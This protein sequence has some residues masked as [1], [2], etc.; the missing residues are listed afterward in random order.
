MIGENK[1]ETI[2]IAQ[3]ESQYKVNIEIKIN[4]TD[5]LITTITQSRVLT[6]NIIP[7][8]SNDT[9]MIPV[10]DYIEGSNIKASI[11]FISNDYL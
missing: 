8:L 11:S 5:D 10:E 7:S 1:L 4:V 3:S 6:Q 9:F 2:S